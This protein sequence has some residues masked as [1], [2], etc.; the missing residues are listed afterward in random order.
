MVKLDGQKVSSSEELMK[1]LEYYK[2]GET[3]SITLKR[4]ENGEYVDVELEVTLGNRPEE[5][6]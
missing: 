3:V 1:A 2:A 6:Q 5:D 4:V